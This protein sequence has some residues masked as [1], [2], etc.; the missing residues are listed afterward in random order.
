MRRDGREPSGFAA[1]LEHLV[2]QRAWELPVAGGSLLNHWPAIAASVT[3]A[4]ADH[5]TAVAF[6]PDSGQLDLRPDSAAYAT[7]LRLLTA[8]IIHA[9]NDHAGTE[10]VRSVRVLPI[11]AP[12]PPPHDTHPQSLAPAPDAADAPPWPPSTPPAGLHQARQAMKA[13]RNTPCSRTAPAA[14]V[15]SLLQRE[16]RARHLARLAA[17]PLPEDTT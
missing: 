1:V 17:R 6:H 2:A 3:P 4:L 10:T 7:Q 8:R 11:G 9:A 14:P 16:D 12:P 15:S 5:V 13:H